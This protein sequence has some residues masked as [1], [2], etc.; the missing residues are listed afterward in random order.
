MEGTHTVTP[1][2]HAA[3]HDDVAHM[4]ALLAAG[5]DVDERVMKGWTPLHMAA[6]QFSLE[7]AR[8]LLDSG[9][10]IDPIDSSGRTPLFVAVYSTRGRANMIALLRAQGADPFI[11]DNETMSPIQLA[12]GFEGAVPA[13]CFDDLVTA[14]E[15]YKSLV[16]DHLSPAFRSM[17][18]KGGSGR[19]QLP[20]G[21]RGWLLVRFEKWKYSNRAEIKFRISSFAVSASEWSKS[22][23]SQA[24]RQPDGIS[25]YHDVNSRPV[26]LGDGV[27]GVDHWWELNAL[28]DLS[29]LS[30]RIN[31]A[32]RTHGMPWL[33][34]RATEM[35]D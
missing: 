34:D 32:M 30:E 7:A 28:T 31:Q 21:D 25:H 27:L 33:R 16:H 14:Q 24:G 12:L 19:Y 9:A 2:H 3:Y 22:E 8:L 20:V 6:Q 17:G 35:K 5:A 11:E 1:L 23:E 26:C 4:R 13:H 15:H 10:A 18:L 29:Q